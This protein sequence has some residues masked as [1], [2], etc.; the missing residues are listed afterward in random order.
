M[1]AHANERAAL[2]PSC[3]ADPPPVV[4]IRAPVTATAVAAEPLSWQQP[5][6]INS[7]TEPFV[8]E[9]FVVG[10]LAGL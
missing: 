5:Y 1:R 2:W 3:F 10:C 4:P 9:K 8:T 6:T 7:L